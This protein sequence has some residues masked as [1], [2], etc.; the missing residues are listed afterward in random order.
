MK[1]K[2]LAPYGMFKQHQPGDII[3]VTEVELESF[4]DK[5]ELVVEEKPKSTPKR[6]TKK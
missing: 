1:A 3:E 5:L 4:P 6:T 2:V